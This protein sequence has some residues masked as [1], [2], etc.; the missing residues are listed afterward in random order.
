MHAR[1]SIVIPCRNDALALA[2]TLDHLSTL[3]HAEDAEVIV[4]ASG[5]EAR[6]RAA[7]SG[8]ARL[9]WPN[10]S[11]RAELLNAGAAIAQAPILLFLHA[12]SYLP[13]DTIAQIEGAL[14]DPAVRSGAFEHRFLEAD[15]RLAV[16]SMINRVRYRV[17]RNYYGDQAQFVRTNTFRSVGGFARVRMMEDLDLSQRLK[18]VGRTALVRTPIHTSGRRFLQRGPWRTLVQC[19]LLLTL[20]ACRGN[21]DRYAEFWRG[22]DHQPPGS[23]ASASG[24]ERSPVTPA[25][26]GA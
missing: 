14:R 12:D 18:R 21:V 10:G 25:S 1:V 3:V 24:L 6:T 17:T 20:R 8:R 4:A 15:W 13:T 26:D 16:I 23:P 2:A 7:A 22:P 11:T 5:D 19:G 9:V